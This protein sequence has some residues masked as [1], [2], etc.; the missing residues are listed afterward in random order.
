M[1]RHPPSPE[2]LRAWM[3]QHGL[4]SREVSELVRVRSRV[5]RN[6]ASVYSDLEIPYGAWYTLRT[7][8]E[9]KPPD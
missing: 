7:K 3:D 5:V 9:G 6:W 2:S 4:S 8:V 1:D